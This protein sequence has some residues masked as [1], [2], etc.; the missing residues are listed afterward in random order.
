M[1]NLIY[2]SRT[3]DEIAMGLVVDPSPRT[4]QL[5]MVRVA[6]GGQNASATMDITNFDPGFFVVNDGVK[7]RYIYVC[8]RSVGESVNFRKSYGI[9]YVLDVTRSID[10]SHYL[11]QS[12]AERRLFFNQMVHVVQLFLTT[13]GNIAIYCNNGRSRS[14]ALVAAY[15]VVAECFSAAGAYKYLSSIFQRMRHSDKNIDREGRFE[16]YI[17]ELEIIMKLAEN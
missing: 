7:Y 8:C 1:I 15:F 6:E 13:D 2:S 4:M 14:P 3:R 16:K 11:Y 12:E 5:K 10:D 17:D 9:D